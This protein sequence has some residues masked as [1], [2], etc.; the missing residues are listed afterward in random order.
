MARD[1]PASEI[2]PGE[3]LKSYVMIVAAI[4]GRFAASSAR[5]IIGV[6]PYR[7]GIFAGLIA[8]I[9]HYLLSR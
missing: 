6:G 8:A 1:R 5:S 4:S 9:V 3:I 7:T 2:S